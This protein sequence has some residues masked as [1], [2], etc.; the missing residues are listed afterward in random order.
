MDAETKG[1]ALDKVEAIDEFVAYPNE[2]LDA[3]K[4]D[5]Y[6]ARL[7][8]DESGDYFGSVLRLAKFGCDRNF[9]KLHAPVNKSDW[10]TH[11]RAAVVNAFYNLVEN[12]I[13]FPAGKSRARA[14]STRRV[15]RVCPTVSSPG[16]SS[17][18]RSVGRLRDDA[19]AVDKYYVP[20]PPSSLLPC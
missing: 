10:V 13:Q 18:K 2:L 20:E 8:L 14:V 4:V 12:S 7:R 5:D 9:E 1:H 11:G 6:Y 17:R 19:A 15:L 16:N 3:A